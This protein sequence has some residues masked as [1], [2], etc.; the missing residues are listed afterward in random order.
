MPLGAIREEGDEPEHLCSFVNDSD[1][2]NLSL[3]LHSLPT[4]DQIG[5][6]LTAFRA[7]LSYLSSFA[8]FVLQESHMSYLSDSFLSPN[9]QKDRRCPI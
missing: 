3:F 2:P 1:I 6:I 8:A 7:M 4:T 9:A 5:P